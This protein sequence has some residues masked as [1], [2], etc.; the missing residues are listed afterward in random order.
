MRPI[1]PRRALAPGIWVH[2]PPGSSRAIRRQQLYIA[3]AYVNRFLLGARR[4]AGCR[5]GVLRLHTLWGRSPR[6]R[7]VRAAAVQLNAN[8]DK[9][10][11]LRVADRLTRAAAAEGADLIVL[12]EKFNLL[13]EAEHYRA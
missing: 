1:R 12:P 10:A 5:Q 2:R 9:Q 3:S 13:G 4:L 11:N 7:T 6:R 8:E